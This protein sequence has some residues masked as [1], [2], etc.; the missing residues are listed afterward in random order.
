MDSRLKPGTRTAF[1]KSVG[2]RDD[3]AVSFDL[4]PWYYENRYPELERVTI[5]AEEWHRSNAFDQL[6]GD[7]KQ[8]LFTLVITKSVVVLGQGNHTAAISRI[9][10]LNGL[11]ISVFFETEQIL[12]SP[13]RGGE[14]LTSELVTKL[15][16]DESEKKS[17][18][19]RNP[20]FRLYEMRSSRRKGMKKSEYI[21][22]VTVCGQSVKVGLD[23]YGQC[24]FIEYKKDGKT[25]TESCGSYNTDYM[26]YIYARF[27]SEYRRL[28]LRALFGELSADEAVR[29]EEYRV[30]FQAA[31]MKQTK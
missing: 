25:I 19:M 24:Y 27:D 22:T 16:E 28:S 18:M 13:G 26:D 7:A 23:D 5:Y 29:L 20:P 8:G 31:R 11:G 12:I 3:N 9:R 15:A 14:L 2:R 4:A 30:S 10:Q 6:I 17:R 1:Y 21:T